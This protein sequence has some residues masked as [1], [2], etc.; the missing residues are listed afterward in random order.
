MQGMG[1]QKNPEKVGEGLGRVSSPLQ[2]LAMGIV[3]PCGK[4]EALHPPLV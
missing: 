1:A 2:C 3:S 4:H